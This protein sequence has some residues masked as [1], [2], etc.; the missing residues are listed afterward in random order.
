LGGANKGPQ[1]FVENRPV[2]GGEAVEKR[3]NKYTAPW[4]KAY[5]ELRKAVKNQGP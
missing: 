2:K 5:L 3:Y 4:K 1:R